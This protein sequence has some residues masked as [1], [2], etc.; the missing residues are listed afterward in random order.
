VKLNLA[1]GLDFPVDLAT[2]T[3]LVVGKRGTGKSNTCVRLA[4]ELYRAKVPFVALDPTDTWWGL[5]ASGDGKGPGLEVYVFGG[6]HKDLPLEPTAG[7]LV[8]DLFIERRISGVLA[9]KHFSGAERAR[10]VEVFCTRLLERNTDPLHVFLEEAHELAPQER[11]EKGENKMLGAVKRLWTRGRS[12]GLSGSAITQRP[13]SLHKTVTTQSEILIVHRLLGPQDVAAIK[14][15]IKYHG[16]SNEI[17]GQ[18]STLK[19]GEA[20]VWAPDFPEGKPLGLVRVQILRRT[21]FDSAATPKAG[22]R[23]T[24]PKHL[25]A[26]D[27][28]AISGAM[29][30]T[31]ERAKADDPKALRAE[32]ARVKA[33]LAKA[34]VATKTERVEV[35]VLGENDIVKLRGLVADL[36]AAG[37]R[38]CEHAA[39][40]LDAVERAAA[41]KRAPVS[42]ERRVRELTATNGAAHP[43]R[44][45]PAAPRAGSGKFHGEPLPRGVRAILTAVAQ[46]ASGVTREQLTVLTG[47]KRSS[48]DTYLQR[49][50]SDDM[51]E[52]RGGQIVATEVGLDALGPDFEP[53]PTGDALREHWLGKLPEGERRILEIVVAKHPLAVDREVISEATGYARSSRDTYL[54]RLS[55]RRLVDSGRDGVRASEELFDA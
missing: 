51:V 49:L 16:E 6:R 37:R 55:A 2:Q 3:L 28:E 38:A 17:L 52:E 7:A 18:L 19:A 47:Y 8:A 27:I 48:R 9:M 14:E 32:L 21:T 4:E 10:F 26:V 13:A 30:A 35:P 40:M 15:W 23:R 29:A 43:R 54:Q 53:L 25:A 42:V 44:E 45:R 36:D 41:A 5:K 50:G 46:H 39:K 20:F 1:E 11:D 34:Q 12:S 24:E 33:E 31:I 22:E